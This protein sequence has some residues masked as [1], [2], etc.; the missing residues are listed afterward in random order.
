V[1]W[2]AAHREYRRLGRSPEQRQAAYRQL[3][4]AAVAKI[5]DCT[6]NGWALG[7]TRFSGKIEVP[8]RRRTVSKGVGQPQNGV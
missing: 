7:S 5:R 2:L 1:D 8:T 6:H 4:R 3:F